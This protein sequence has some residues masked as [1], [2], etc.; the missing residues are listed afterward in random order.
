M[1]SANM[2]TNAI[3]G[4]TLS[5]V[6]EFIEMNDSFIESAEEDDDSGDETVVVM[7]KM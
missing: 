7:N 2:V 3:D 1:T 5:D 6:D 4:V